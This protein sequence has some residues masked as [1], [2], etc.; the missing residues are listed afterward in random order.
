MAIGRA[1]IA[2]EC[3][4]QP[5]QET[6][7]HPEGGAVEPDRRSVVVPRLSTIRSPSPAGRASDLSWTEEGAN[8]RQRFDDRRGRWSD[9]STHGHPTRGPS[10]NRAA[11]RAWA[12]AVRNA[13]VTKRQS[14]SAAGRIRSGPDLRKR[15]GWVE[16]E[17]I[18]G[19]ARGGPGLDTGEL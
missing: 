17:T 8:P 7:V 3:S 14:L 1:M 18:D 16:V 19:L 10:H 4:L 12:S 6:R 9:A 5:S 2:R 15:A 11:D 13:D